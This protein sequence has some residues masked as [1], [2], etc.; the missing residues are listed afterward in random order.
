MTMTLTLHRCSV[1]QRSGSMCICSGCKNV[2]CL[3]DFNEHRHQLSTRF[4]HDILRFHDDL[5]GR[6]KQ[7]N[8]SSNELFSQI[9]RWETRTIDKIHHA[10]ERARQKLIKVLNQEREIFKEQWEN[11]T[12]QIRYQQ[13]QN[14]FVETDIQL[15]RN[16][17]IK[18]QQTFRQIT[19]QEKSNIVLVENNKI[20]WNNLIYPQKQQSNSK[21]IIF[22]STN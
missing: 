12:K 13:E 15:L 5:L 9:N 16:K 11:I 14:N 3:K 20:N 4:D 1:C 8:D 19:G 7:S 18:M 17:L 6:I 21:S 2:F 10:A 22:V